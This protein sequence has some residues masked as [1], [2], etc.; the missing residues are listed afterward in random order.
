MITRELHEAYIV[1]MFV[2]N[3]KLTGCGDNNIG[4]CTCAGG[5]SVASP[6]SGNFFPGLVV[7]R[8]GLPRNYNSLLLAPVMYA[9]QNS[10][11]ELAK[12]RGMAI[13]FA[14]QHTSASGGTYAD[15]STGDGV[16]NAPLW[17]NTTVSSTADMA[18]I[19][20]Y[21][22]QLDVGIAGTIG[23][24]LVSSSSTGS[25]YTVS[26]GATSTGQAYYAGAGA[27]YDLTGAKRYLRAVGKPILHTTACGSLGTWLSGAYVFGSPGEAPPSLLST[28]NVMRRILVTTPCAT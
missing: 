11:D 4:T 13:S 22:Y 18:A 16:H 12:V 19:D 17:R 7:D 26:A 9:E 25:G 20:N 23:G 2:H 24:M 8:L 5:V 1:P 27:V 28:D 3:A 6:S 21:A 14:L 15:Y 10:S